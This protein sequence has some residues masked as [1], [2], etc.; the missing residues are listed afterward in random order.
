MREEA[1]V[2]GH[3]SAL[4]GIITEPPAAPRSQ[5]YPAVLLLNAGLLHRV[6]PNRLYVKLARSLAALGCVVLRFDLSGFGDSPVRDD[7]LPVEQRVVRET[8]EAMD[9]L[10]ATRGIERFV[11]MGICS[12]AAIALKTACGDARVVGVVLINTPGQLY[13]TPEEVHRALARHYWRLAVSSSFRA[14]NWR[15]VIRGNFD[16]RSVIRVLSFRLRGLFVRQR[17]TAAGV[18]QVAVELHGVTARGVQLLMVHA[19]GDEGLDYI[20]VILGDEIRE[21]SA[22]GRLRV[23]VIV[24]ANHTFTLLPNQHQLLQVVQQWVQ[25]L[26]R[27][28]PVTRQAYPLAS[29][30]ALRLD[31]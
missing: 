13:A 29:M 22:G 24:G 10:R 5:D 16:Y 23:E 25:A 30:T 27:P 26:G 4:V 18:R 3:A 6:G 21:L 9:Y 28:M 15:K 12:G 14:K 11:L 7:T 2:F 17:Q 19:E 1:V 8:Q 31:S 20:E